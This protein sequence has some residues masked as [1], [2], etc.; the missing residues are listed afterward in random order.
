MNRAPSSKPNIPDARCRDRPFCAH[1][2][3][4]LLIHIPSVCIPACRARPL[5]LLCLV[6]K[7]KPIAAALKSTQAFV[8]Q[9]LTS[10]FRFGPRQ[11]TKP[12]KADP[13]PTPAP[14]YAVKAPR[15]LHEIRDTNVIPPPRHRPAPRKSDK[16]SLQTG[17]GKLLYPSYTPMQLNAVDHKP[18]YPCVLA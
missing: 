7:T 14:R 10:I 3:N 1:A 6:R 11:E 15:G 8:L 17:Q 5:S 18:Y 9:G 4:G 12:I 2:Q 13:A 16:A